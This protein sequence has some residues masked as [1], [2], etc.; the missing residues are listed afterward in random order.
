MLENV[1]PTQPLFE[2][3][4]KP[5]FLKKRPTQQIQIRFHLCDYVLFSLQIFLTKNFQSETILAISL[6]KEFSNNFLFINVDLWQ[7]ESVK[8]K[9]KESLSG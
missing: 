5:G 1:F 4:Y 6:Y 9:K 3:H 7:S 2:I 8:K